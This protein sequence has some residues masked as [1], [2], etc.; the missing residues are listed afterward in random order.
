MTMSEIAKKL[1][2]SRQRVHQILK[3]EGLPHQASNQ[4]IFVRMSCVR[5][6]KR[7][8]ILQQRVQKAMANDSNCLHKMREAVLQNQTPIFHQLSPSQ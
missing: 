5:H 1:N 2:I 6:N 3:A 7:L 4:E 8:Q